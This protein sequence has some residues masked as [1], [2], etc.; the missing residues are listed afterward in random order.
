[1]SQLGSSFAESY[2]NF[3]KFFSDS[4][5]S[6]SEINS[7][8]TLHSLKNYSNPNKINLNMIDTNN[9]NILFH[10]IR[11]SKSDDECL[12][13]LK[14]LI[15]KYNI[16]YE[17]FDIKRR[18]LPYYSCVKGFLNTTKY[19]LE[20]MNY[21]IAKKDIN[22][23]TLFFSAMRSYNIELV[24]YLDNKYVNWISEPNKDY[25]YCIFNIFKKSM[26]DEGEKKIKNL[27]KY[28]IGKGFD[29]NEKNK[30][31]NNVSF[32]DLCVSYQIE[33]YLDESLN[34]INI[35]KKKIMKKNEEDNKNNYDNLDNKKSLNKEKN[36]NI[37]INKKEVNDKSIISTSNSSLRL[38]PNNSPN[39]KNI[40]EK[41]NNIIN[42]NNISMD[43]NNKI[44]SKKKK[45]CCIFVSKKNEDQILINKIYDKLLK[46]EFFKKKYA[47]KINFNL[48]IP[49]FE[50]G[51]ISVIKKS[52]KK[53]N[54]TNDSD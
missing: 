4:S 50:K 17:I 49:S 20:K 38:L 31:K 23:E 8:I 33:K 40:L 34:E 9:L 3:F 43:S 52:L 46:A 27:M 39:S 37:D 54:N 44:K 1:M 42:L 45:I 13:K 21:D 47:D 51:T 7:F 16:N 48:S 6:I 29:T 10:I 35:S 41:D 28:I 25:Y 15:E 5:K 53:K 19:L 2:T 26:K 30:N 22:G 14:L 12:E 18:T 11:K 36:I 24:K 32:R